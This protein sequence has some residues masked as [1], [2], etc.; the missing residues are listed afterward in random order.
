MAREEIWSDYGMDGSNSL[1][2]VAD[3]SCEL[4][5]DMHTG[6]RSG[7]IFVNADGAQEL[8]DALDTWLERKD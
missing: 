7:C 4:V 3:D 8:R 2:V 5:F 1:T 6:G